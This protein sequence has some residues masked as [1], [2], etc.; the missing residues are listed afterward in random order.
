VR[1]VQ[2]LFSAAHA[3]ERIRGYRDRLILGKRFLRPWRKRKEAEVILGYFI[4]RKKD[5][6]WK[7]GRAPD[8]G[9]SGGSAVNRL[10]RNGTIARNSSRVVGA[11]DGDQRHN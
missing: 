10:A 8:T 11:S 2:N 5:R 7:R 9:A 6:P 1:D 4:I 3:D